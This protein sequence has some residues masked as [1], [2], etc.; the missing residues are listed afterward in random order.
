MKKAI[1]IMVV[2][3]GLVSF[4]KEDIKGYIKN[5]SCIPVLN[6]ES[7]LNKLN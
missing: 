6:T 3:I 1:I 2:F 4:F 7:Q 5:T